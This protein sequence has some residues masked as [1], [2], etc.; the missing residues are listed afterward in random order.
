MSIADKITQLTT[1]RASMREKLVAKGVDAST[2]NFADFPN[3][4][5]SIP[6]GGGLPEI[7]INKSSPT[8]K[9]DVYVNETDTF[10][11][12]DYYYAIPK[13]NGNYSAFALSTAQTEFRLLTRFRL[14]DNI[15]SGTYQ[16][17]F[18]P[19]QYA[20]Y[21]YLFVQYGNVVKFG[22][23]AEG[24]STVPEIEC[25]TVNIN[26]WYYVVIVWKS[27]TQTISCKLYGDDGTK[28]W[29]YDY[30]GMAQYTSANQRNI[31]IGGR[32]GAAITACRNIDIDVAQ[33]CFEIDGV[34]Q[35]GN[36]NSKTQ[37]MG[38]EV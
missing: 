36:L 15:P 38:L 34:I 32:G 6:S 33:T 5:E 3:D 29:Q 12:A 9:S 26:T 19:A 30:Q 35:W 28:I 8:V 17:L 23:Q 27:A 24:S 11:Y 10:E 7:R 21:P 25:G 4:V 13:R 18:A 2:H 31:A 37:N 22:C 1:I 16:C 20:Y 14:T